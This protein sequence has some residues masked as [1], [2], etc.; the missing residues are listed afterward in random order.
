MKQPSS[1]LLILLA[2][3]FFLLM[4]SSCQDEII[5]EVLRYSDYRAG[6]YAPID[7]DEVTMVPGHGKDSFTPYVE[8]FVWKVNIDGY[9]ADRAYSN[10]GESVVETIELDPENPSDFFIRIEDLYD[11][12]Y[13]EY[14]QR[15]SSTG[16]GGDFVFY[17][18]SFI[19]HYNFNFDWFMSNERAQSNLGET[20]T[21]SNNHAGYMLEETITYGDEFESF[22]TPFGKRYD[23]CLHVTRSYTFPQGF[24]YEP[25]ITFQEYYI[26]KG[27]GFVYLKSIYNTG[28]ET[29]L[30]LVD[31]SSFGETLTFDM[32]TTDTV[33]KTIAPRVY[34]EGEQITLPEVNHEGYILSSWLVIVDDQEVGTYEPGSSFSMGDK[35]VTMKAVWIAE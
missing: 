32:N 10:L 22:T 21:T 3:L 7:Q 2:F 31:H 18:P 27:V 4:F 23:T 14:E 35:D 28:E 19:T 12:G 17:I 11:N 13:H 15:G 29:Q 33:S 5:D 20:I 6:L 16:S 24:E 26:A 30:V 9:E 25:Y 1:N 8:G 34:E